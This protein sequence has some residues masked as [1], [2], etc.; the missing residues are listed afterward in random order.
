VKFRANQILHTI[1]KS[2]QFTEE[3]VYKILLQRSVMF[4]IV[5]TVQASCL[6]TPGGKKRDKEGKKG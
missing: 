4:H 2:Y 6:K 5:S 1:M 3:A